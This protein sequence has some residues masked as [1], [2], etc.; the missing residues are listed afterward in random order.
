MLGWTMQHWVT[1]IATTTVV[2]IVVNKVPALQKL[3]Q[4]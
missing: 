4:G 1:A 3:V 2:L